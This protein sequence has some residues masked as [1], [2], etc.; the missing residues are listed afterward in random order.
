M[1]TPLTIYADFN[2]ADAE[3][4]VRLGGKGTRRDLARMGLRLRSGMT[5][6]VHDEE[7]TAVGVVEYS[8]AERLWA[9]RIDWSE[10]REWTG[11]AALSGTEL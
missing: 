11:E 4:R 8:S 5:L 7:L 2:N 3:G 9:V 10:V 1:N 6:T